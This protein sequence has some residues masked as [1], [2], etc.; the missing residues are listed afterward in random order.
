IGGSLGRTAATASGV[1]M[2]A[3]M[4]LRHFGIDEMSASYAVQGMGN[5]GGLTAQI[6]FDGG[7]KVTC[8]SDVNGCVRNDK[9]LNI[10]EIRNFLQNGG[11]LNEYKAEGVEQ[12]QR[13]AILTIDCDVLIPCALENQ[14]TK[15]NAD[16]VQAKIVVEGANGPTT[17]E[18]DEILTKRGIPVVP[19]ILANSGGVVVS[20]FE[21]VQD[22]QNYYW[23]EKDVAKRLTQK[24]ELAF[25]AVVDQAKKYD[26]S[27][28]KGAYAV[29][30]GR[31]IT[32]AKFRKSWH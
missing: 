11:K 13:E 20:Y 12:L 27:L 10:T 16:K 4:A 25:K 24:M 6:L 14:L 31:I 21:W 2:I 9:G 1:C 26:T 23:D 29:A 5:V 19:D 8:V 7:H 15:E 17:P 28:R 3:K 32:A 30:I 22:L 18:A